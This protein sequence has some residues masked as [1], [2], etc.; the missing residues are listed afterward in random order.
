MAQSAILEPM[1]P[2]T[3]EIQEKINELEASMMAPDFWNDK[4]QAQNVIKE[5]QELKDQLAGVG[6]YDRG[7]A[8][9]TILA[10]AGGDDAEDFVRMLLHMYTK[11]IETKG[12]SLNYL[13]EHKTDNGGYRNV[14][15][16][17]DG[18]NVY[19]ALKYEA[20]VHR[21]V[22]ISPF[23]AQGKRQTSFAMVEVMPKIE[24]KDFSGIEIPSED[25]EINFARSSGPGGQNV[26]KR[27]T[28]VRLTHKPSGVSFHVESER[29][30]EANREKAMQMLRGKLAQLLEEQEKEKIEDLSLNKNNDNEWGN[31]M[32]SYVLHP[33]QMV[34]DHRTDLE[35]R[36]V[37]KVLDNGDLDQFIQAAKQ[38]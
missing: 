16:E 18:K 17:I 30:Q 14:T 3:N 20:G 6:K 7:N 24:A 5:I 4:V 15:I 29:S 23:N 22:R 35:V 28:A 31:Q 9:M 37:D 12:W 13:H 11:Y 34:K 1:S 25:I 19:G 2:S 21:L 36:T 27:D 32:R 26:N 33:Y 38:L 10:G 8:V